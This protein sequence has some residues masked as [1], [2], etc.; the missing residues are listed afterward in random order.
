MSIKKFFDP[1]ANSRK[2]LTDQEQKE[3]FK[4]IINQDFYVSQ[5]KSL[6]NIISN[7]FKEKTYLIREDK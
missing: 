3:A 7:F 5:R 6:L 2:Y 4:E 1:T